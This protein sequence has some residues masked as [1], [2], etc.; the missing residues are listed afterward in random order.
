MHFT[1]FWVIYK[2]QIPNKGKYKIKNFILKI[3]EIIC[4]NILD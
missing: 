2:I 1:F 4:H 3:T